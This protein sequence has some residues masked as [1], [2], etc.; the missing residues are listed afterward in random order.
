[1]TTWIIDTLTYEID[2]TS[3]LPLPHLTP[4]ILRSEIAEAEADT[5]SLDD[6]I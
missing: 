1:M 4:H 5:R 2:R 6:G 3:V